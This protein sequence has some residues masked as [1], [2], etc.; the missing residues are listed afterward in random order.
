MGVHTRT[1]VLRERLRHEGGVNALLHRYFLD[2]RAEGHD[3][4]RS[5]QRIC[6]AQV[7]LV[8]TRASFVVAEFDRDS[9]VFEHAHG[10]TT[11]VVGGST[12]NVVEVSSCVY[13]LCTTVC[14]VAVLEEIELNLRVSVESEATFCSLSQRALE[15][16]A[17]VRNSRL[18]VRSIDVAEHA[19]RGV[20]FTTP[21]KNLESAGVR[22]GE[23]I[24][25]IGTGQTFNGRTIDTNTF[26]EGT[27]DLCRCYSN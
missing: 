21:R 2:H 5:G 16:V 24:C 20:Y 1:G 11:E 27:F 26:S 14:P 6:I 9:D 3:V 17:R 4:V 18:A 22:V 15:N 19:S 23:N 8:L 25:L 12:R 7:N 13:G 10:A